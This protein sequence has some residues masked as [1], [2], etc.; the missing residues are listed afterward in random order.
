MTD[1]ELLEVRN[2]IFLEDGI[3]A[4]NSVGFK[5]S[6]F[7]TD[8]YGRDYLNDF[9]YSLCRLN[10]SCLE[11]IE[12]QITRGDRWIKVFLNIF[13]LIPTITDLDDL[14]T[15]DSLRYKIP[16]ASLTEMRINHDNYQGIPLFNSK[17]N[18]HKLS[19]S[20][21]GYKKSVKD[22]RTNIQND[23]SNID[24]FVKR[25]HEISKPLQVDWN[26]RIYGIED[27]TI[28]QRLESAS[29]KERFYNV[30]KKDV[31]EAERILKWLEA[32]EK[33]IRNMIE[34]TANTVQARA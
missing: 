22:L 17:S 8:W 32:D 28:E 14:K 13:N 11:T 34:T 9:T 1:K 33:S 21:A 23:L 20:I 29:L 7:P 24:S 16:P 2:E 4:L 30:V 12:A 25:W 15:C 5:K 6:P 19:R 18:R 27:M 10:H 26:G 31:L 3:P